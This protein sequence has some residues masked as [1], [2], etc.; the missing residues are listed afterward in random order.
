MNAVNK[1][2]NGKNI[3]FRHNKELF[4]KIVS[5]YDF[6]SEEVKNAYGTCGEK[7]ILLIMCYNSEYGWPVRASSEAYYV[8]RDKRIAFAQDKFCWW[9]KKTDIEEDYL[10]DE[11][12]TMDN[13]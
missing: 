6:E 10:L 1:N 9:L 4:G 7:G 3:Y 2:L 11:R 13:E 5:D 12:K 8:L